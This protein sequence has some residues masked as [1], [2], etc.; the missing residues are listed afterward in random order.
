MTR[1]A[2]EHLAPDIAN[3]WLALLRP[4]VRLVAARSTEPRVALLGGIPD[5]PTTHEWPTWDGVG[6]LT[7]IGELDLAVVARFSLDITLPPDGRLLFFYFDGSYN[8]WENVAETVG[9]FEPASLA[10]ARMV[11][12][13]AGTP[14]YPRQAPEGVRVLP[15]VAFAGQEVVTF[16]S[17]EHPDLRAAFGAPD[18]D[19]KSWV[20]HPVCADAFTE[21][22]WERHRGVQHQIGGYATTVQGPVE[23]EAAWGVLGGDVAT[24][25]PAEA[26]VEAARWR[27]LFQMDSDDDLD[28]MWGD[29]GMLYWLARPEDLNAGDLTRATFTWQCA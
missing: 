2:A 21:A 17:F 15:R 29:A 20:A 4:A 6:P 14:A 23:M 22:L 18:A 11:Y 19:F 3:R 5:L 24:I 7:F 28:A 27:P 12:V 9:Y 1:I 16:P 25:D 26:A 13:P 8:N 10:G